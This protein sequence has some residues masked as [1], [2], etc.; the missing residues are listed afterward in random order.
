M[1]YPSLK[2]FEPIRVARSAATAEGMMTPRPE[3]NSESG[4]ITFADPRKKQNLTPA[5]NGRDS[6]ILTNRTSNSERVMKIE[7]RDAISLLAGRRLGTGDAA[8]VLFQWR[9]LLFI[10]VVGSLIWAPGGE[11]D[12]LGNQ[13]SASIHT[14]RFLD[15]QKKTRLTQRVKKAPGPLLSPGALDFMLISRSRVIREKRTRQ[16]I[17]KSSRRDNDKMK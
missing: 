8:F 16:T 7:G 4:P 1:I 11:R 14:S 6:D 2:A 12:S 9:C 5:M 10:R 3:P 17:I 15:I 13:R